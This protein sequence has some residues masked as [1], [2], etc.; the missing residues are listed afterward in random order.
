MENNN[1]IAFFWIC[2]SIILSFSILLAGGTLLTLYSGGFVAIFG[3]FAYT[4]MNN[5]IDS[6]NY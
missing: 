2:F 6:L 1:L 5:E 3:L 4:I